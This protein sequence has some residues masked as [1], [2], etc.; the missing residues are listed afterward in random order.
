MHDMFY[1][2]DLHGQKDLFIA[3]RAWCLRQDEECTI[4]YGGDACDRGEHGY[5]IMNMLLADPQILYLKGNH[6]DLFVKAARELIGYYAR[7]DE[8]YNAFHNCHDAETAERLIRNGGAH[9][10]SL[11]CYNGGFP[12]LR[13]WILDGADDE[14]VDKI[15]ELPVTFSY[16]GVD[17]CH[18]GGTYSAFKAVNDAEYW[19]AKPNVYAI[20]KCIWDRNAI[21]LGW[22]TDRICVHG[23]TPTILLPRGIYGTD[24]SEAHAH[25]CA[26]QDHMGGKEKRGGWKIDMDTGATWTGR[27]YVL[28]VLT[29]H[30][31]GF[32]DHRVPENNE[33]DGIAIE[34]EFENYKII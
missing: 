15:D 7:N 8:S 5:E 10:V 3:M 27:A 12:T 21:A 11:H 25:P 17:F 20:D 30:V 31:T 14:F 13:D 6:E 33:P 2:T 19:D 22:E 34:E 26:W 16:E 4:V 18:A 23:H 29:M 9:D 1:F 28:N 24:Q 32:F